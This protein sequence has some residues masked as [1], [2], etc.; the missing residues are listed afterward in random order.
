MELTVRNYLIGTKVCINEAIEDVKSN[1]NVLSCWSL[2]SGDVEEE[3][4]DLLLTEII[5]LWITIRGYSY[6][7]NL[8]EQYRQAIK[9]S[10]K[11]KSLC[12]SLKY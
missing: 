5:K 2:I 11:K 1:D 8:P 9:Q 10:A 4:Q 7:D 3:I 12:K 6:T